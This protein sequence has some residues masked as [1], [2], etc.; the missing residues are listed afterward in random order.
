MIMHYECIMRLTNTRGVTGRKRW[1][2]VGTKIN[3]QAF[4]INPHMLIHWI[5]VSQE[6]RLAWFGWFRL[7]CLPWFG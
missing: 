2:V 4:I 1:R 3:I 6:L 7:G 5:W